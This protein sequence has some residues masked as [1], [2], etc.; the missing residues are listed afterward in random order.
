MEP[1]NTP[2]LRDAIAPLL[3]LIDEGL[4]LDG[5]RVAQRPLRAAWQL[6]TDFVPQVNVGEGPRPPGRPAEFSQEPWF[7][8]VYAH[9]EEWYRARYGDRIGGRGRQLMR[10]VTLV[11]AT[12]FELHVPI[13]ASRVEVEGETAWLSFPSTVRPDDDVLS[14]VVSAPA[15]DTYSADVRQRTVELASRIA[16]LLRR[17][18]C[19]LTGALANDEATRNLLPGVRLHL[20][21]AASLIAMEDEEGSFAR[22]QWELQMAIESAY[23]A[24]LQQRTGD[25]SETHDLFV[26]NDRAQVPEASVQ[27]KWLREL[28]RWH[29]AANLR[30]GLG[31]HPTVVGIM[32]WYETALKIIAGVTESLDGVDLTQASMLLRMAPWI[33]PIDEQRGDNLPGAAT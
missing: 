21:S 5:V 12:P 6:V 33:R 22:A 29:D 25:F 8:P 11:S 30:Y 15:W 18:S 24:L 1:V 27:R 28:P 26:L 31:D 7:R 19:R 32:A 2:S 3:D 14:W 10:G 9:V 17:V 4:G 20:H 23:K 13:T 16:T